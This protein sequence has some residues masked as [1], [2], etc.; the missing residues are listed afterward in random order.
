MNYHIELEFM[1]VVTERLQSS[2]WNYVPVTA[3]I[4]AHAG[5]IAT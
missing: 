1:T 3:G 5:P 2:T 4:C